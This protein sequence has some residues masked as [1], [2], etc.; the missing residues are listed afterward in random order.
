MNNRR[1]LLFRKLRSS[2]FRSRSIA[3]RTPRPHLAVSIVVL[4][5]CALIIF[6]SDKMTLAK[7][8]GQ[9]VAIFASAIIKTFIK[10]VVCTAFAGRAEEVNEKWPR[11]VKQVCP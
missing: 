2:L 1:A 10:R 8:S 3:L 5:A 6:V 9:R 11:T 7:T 4:P